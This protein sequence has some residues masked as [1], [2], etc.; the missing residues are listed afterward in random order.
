MSDTYRAVEYSQH[1]DSSVL[2][3]GERPVPEPGP[4]QVRLAVRAAG[5]NPFDWKVRK[6]LFG[7][8]MPGKFPAVPGSDVAGVVEAVGPEVTAFAVGDEV[9]GAASGSYAERALASVGNLVPKPATLSWAA[10]AALNTGVTTAYRA[11]ALLNLAA[12]ET[13]LIDGA[14]GTV[15]TV[16]AQI[17]IAR[18]LTVIG[19]ASARNHEYLRSLGVIPVLYG[20]GLIDEVDAIGQVDAA[21]DASGRGGLPALIELTGGTERVITIAD[22]N[23]GS[24]G[25]RFTSGSAEEQVPGALAEGVALAA[26]GKLKLP[27]ATYP[28]VEA[29]E[30]QDESEEG[31]VRGKLVLLV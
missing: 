25:V 31:H 22:G 10:A 1:G 9:L 2:T 26:A 11:L 18:G 8:S 6:G 29:A 21:L 7:P 20:A 4:G 13:L 30:A 28:L 27:V 14:A 19:T 3:V 5:V 12:G 17:A 16:A 24:L 15:G 23:A